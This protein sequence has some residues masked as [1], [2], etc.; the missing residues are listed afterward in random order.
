M[1]ALTRALAAT[2]AAGLGLSLVAA[3]VVAQEAN[4]TAP[5]AASPRAAAPAVLPSLRQWTG[6]PGSFELT[7]KSRIVVESNALQATATTLRDDLELETGHR[8][9]VLRGRAHAGDIVLTLDP[10]TSLG[11]EGYRVDSGQELKIS[12]PTDTG[13]FYGTQTVE[14][15]LKA[16]PHR[17]RVPHGS[18]S[19]WPNFGE[20]AQMLDVGRK[21]YPISYLRSQIRTMAWEKLNTFHLHLSD[22]EG[23]RIDLPQFPGLAAAESYTP[24]QLKDLQAYANRYHVTIIPEVDLPS[25]ATAFTHWDPTLRFSCHSLDYSHWPG[26]QYGGWVMNITTPHTRAFVHDLLAA[27]IPIFDSKVFHIGGD[28][29]PYDADQAACPELVAYQHQRGFTYTGDVFTDFFNSLDEQ[30]RSYGKTTEMW[31]WWDFNNQKTSIQPNKDIIIDSWVNNDPSGLAAQGYRVVGTPEQ[32]LY[33]SAGFGQKP[34]DYGYVDLQNVYE[35]YP[36]EHPAGVLGYRVSRWSDKAETQSPQWLDFFARRPL[37]ILA[38]RTWGGPRS[39]SVWQFFGR[40]DAIG[41]PPPSQLTG[42]SKSAISVTSLDGAAAGEARAML[43]NNPYTKV[44]TTGALP[45]GMT[46]DL[47]VPTRLA[48]LRYEP[49]QD[50]TTAGRIAGYRI[51]VASSPGRWRLAATGTF[52]GD[53]TEQ[54][55]DFAPTHARW[56]RLIALSTSDGGNTVSTAELTPLQAPSSP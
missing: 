42:L 54:E 39:S 19:D 5:S 56:L 43:D 17:T 16:D 49:P 48:G 32:T 14:Q 50:G 37:Q 2:A 52:N 34:G 28:E 44:S 51:E 7:P 31:E 38:E 1:S 3:P 55:V 29:Y 9:R 40:A 36:F 35:N 26:A 33:V 24:A 8:L 22:W 10:D 41:D 53:Q 47:G 12:A 23:F 30:V 6:R 25:H 18:A 4:R 21:Y 11:A 13:V 20:R 46:L 15:I 27:V 45:Q